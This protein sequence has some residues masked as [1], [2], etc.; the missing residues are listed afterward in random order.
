MSLRMN[1]ALVI[2]ALT[3]AAK[4]RGAPALLHPDCGLPL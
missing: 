1:R 2:D 3:L 4:R